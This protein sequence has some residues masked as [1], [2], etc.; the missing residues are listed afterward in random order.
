MITIDILRNGDD[1]IRVTTSGHALFDESGRDVV[2]AGVSVLVINTINSMERFT[3][4]NIEV[5]SNQ[6]KGFI[7]CIINN[8]DNESNL[9]MKSMILGLEEIQKSYSDDYLQIN[10]K[11]V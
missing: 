10:I 4:C 5:T 8:P 2:C 6:D 7:D 11:E 1:F 9:L 3:S